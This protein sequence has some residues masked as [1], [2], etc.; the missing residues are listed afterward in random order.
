MVQRFFEDHELPDPDE[1]WSQPEPPQVAASRT[2]GKRANLLS[3]AAGFL[4]S[5]GKRLKNAG[6]AQPIADTGANDA[7]R[8]PMAQAFPSGGTLNGV[9]ASPEDVKAELGELRREVKGLQDAFLKLQR[10]H[11]ELRHKLGTAPRQSV[12]LPVDLHGKPGAAAFN[13]PPLQMPDMFAARPPANSHAISRSEFAGSTALSSALLEPSVRAGPPTDEAEAGGGI[14]GGLFES[15]MA[16]DDDEVAT[17]TQAQSILG[18]GGQVQP[19]AS[20]YMRPVPSGRTLPGPPPDTLEREGP[21]AFSPVLTAAPRPCEARGTASPGPG[22]PTSKDTRH[23]PLL[24]E[25]PMESCQRHGTSTPPPLHSGYAPSSPASSAS[26]ARLVHSRSASLQG[27]P[28]ASPNFGARLG[29]H[30][31]APFASASGTSTQIPR[32]PRLSPSPRESAGLVLPFPEVD[33]GLDDGGTPSVGS[34]ERPRAGALHFNAN[35]R[36]AGTGHSDWRPTC[37]T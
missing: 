22:T 8:R 30:W 16:P 9:N 11:G 15:C 36:P 28:D 33:D 19:P 14:L 20:Q 17:F 21:R 10:D 37:N 7:C 29:E 35:G 2:Q 31:N 23:L 13:L 25:P 5:S 3:K 12:S 4:S 27:E 18:D 32:S 26:M 34:S 6:T 24:R 1:P